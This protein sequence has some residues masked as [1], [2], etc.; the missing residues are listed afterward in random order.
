MQRATS[1]QRWPGMWKAFEHAV[2]RY[3]TQSSSRGVRDKSYSGETADD[4]W[5]AYLNGFEK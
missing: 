3:W 2:K 5:Q 4:Y 1:M